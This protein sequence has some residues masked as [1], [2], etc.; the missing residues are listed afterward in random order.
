MKF[1]TIL[2]YLIKYRIGELDEREYS[3]QIEY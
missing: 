2:F 1:H 3:E